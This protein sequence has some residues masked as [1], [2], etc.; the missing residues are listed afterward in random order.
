MAGDNVTS[1]LI[2]KR[3]SS[4]GEASSPRTSGGDQSSFLSA[5]LIS[6]T[7]VLLL[8]TVSVYFQWELH[9]IGVQLTNDE[10]HINSLQDTIDSQKQVIKRFNNS[11]T[12]SDVLGRL[13]TLETT[14]KETESALKHDLKDTET[15]IDAQLADTLVL[16]NQTVKIAEDEIEQDVAKVKAD[17]EQYVRTTQDQFS[18]ENDFMVYQLAG[19]FTLLSC[20]ISMWH[21]TAHLRRFNQPVVQRKILAILWYDVFPPVTT[22]IV[23]L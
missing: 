10:S 16:L 9:R 13:K 20:L 7:S 14:M 12:N 3:R 8:I 6:I 11:V 15:K 22:V 5:K 2:R 18:T 4:G 19:T 21:M 17:V 23:V 1:P